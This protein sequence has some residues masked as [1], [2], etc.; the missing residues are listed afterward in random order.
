[1]VVADKR[2]SLARPTGPGRATVSMTRFR[3]ASLTPDAV[4][5]RAAALADR[6]PVG[7]VSSGCTMR[8][9]APGGDRRGEG[10]ATI[11]AIGV[12]GAG[13]LGDNG[14]ASTPVMDIAGS[15][16][17]TLDQAGV[18]VSGD[19]GLVAKNGLARAV[20]GPVRLFII[21]ARRGDD[22]CIHQRAGLHRHRPRPQLPGHQIE[23][24][25]VQTVVDE[26]AAEA[27][28]RSAFRHSLQAREAAKAPERG[29]V[30]E[31]LGELHVRQVMPDRDQQR[32]KQRLRWPRGLTALRHRD[33]FPGRSL[34][35]GVKR[36]LCGGDARLAPWFSLR[37]PL[38][39]RTLALGVDGSKCQ[40]LVQVAP[41]LVQRR[42][43]RHRQAARL[44]RASPGSTRRGHASRTAP[45]FH[46]TRCLWR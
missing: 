1:M 2:A 29:S 28:K 19:M 8:I 14:A 40:P 12:D 3:P 21:P 36:D 27:D 9:A 30:V 20:A 35:A 5:F 37:S 41:R 22:R 6:P 4:T 34:I 23:Q 17:K 13:V 11:G 10:G 31:R 42:R 16:I 24:T 39:P 46:R 43:C 44:M 38:G 33:H 18:C 45:R 32:P 25:L 7:F 15:Y 26:G